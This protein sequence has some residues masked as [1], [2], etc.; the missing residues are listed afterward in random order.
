METT[1]VSDQSQKSFQF[2]LR[3]CEGQ[4]PPLEFHLA[5]GFSGFL[6]ESNNH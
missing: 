3:E 5:T 1:Y 6:E 2:A 4:D